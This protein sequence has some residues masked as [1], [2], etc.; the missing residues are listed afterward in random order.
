MTLE[1]LILLRHGETDWNRNQRLQGHRDIP[2]NAIG[3]HQA[4]DAAPSIVALRPSV[5][6]SSDLS[7]ARETASAVS[8]LTGIE[9]TVDERLR[10]TSMGLW[11]GLTRDE[12][13]AGWPGEWDRWRTTSAHA[14]PPE[15][16]SRWQVAQRANEVVEELDAGTAPRALIVSHGGLIVGLTGRLLRC[17][18][19]A[20]ER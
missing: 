8:A 10:E 7:R 13:V 18:R 12:V 4:L 3:H 16:E 2:L 9:P 20:G 19:T 14:A 5:M 1:H 15:G 17:P 6:V 11:E